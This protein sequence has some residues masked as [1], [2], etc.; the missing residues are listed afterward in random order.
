[1]STLSVTKTYADGAILSEAQ[2]DA[3][4]NSIATFVNTTGLGANNIQDN[5]IGAAEIQTSA[6]TTVKIADGAVTTV[7][8]AD[9]AVTT[10]KLLAALQ[11]YLVPVGQ[12]ASYGGDTAPAGW[13]LCDG[14]AVSRTTYATLFALVGVRFGSGNG[15]TT[16]NAPDLRGRF[17][18]GRD[19]AVARDPNA[20]TRTAM[21]S[22]GATG[23]NVG[24]VQLD[25]FKF[26]NLRLGMNQSTSGGSVTTFG[27]STTST[28]TLS[29]TSSDATKTGLETRPKNAYLNYIIK[30]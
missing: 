25:D 26:T 22:G 18:R 7:K 20:A 9:G 13:L 10:A 2:L 12:V 5:S 19:N 21:N 6:V 4:F 15:T 3:A 16:F 28:G 11:E 24:S 8:I 1:M 29:F 17:I 30:V 27:N 23:D 14:T